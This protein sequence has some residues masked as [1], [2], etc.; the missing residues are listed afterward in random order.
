MGI[1]KI[2]LQ[3]LF[4]QKYLNNKKWRKMFVRQSNKAN[5]VVLHKKKPLLI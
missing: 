1:F 2:F 4:N 5:K 3:I